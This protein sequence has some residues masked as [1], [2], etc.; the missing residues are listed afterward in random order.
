[1]VAINECPASCST[2]TLGRADDLPSGAV[3]H[4]SFLGVINE[5]II[6]DDM[7]L[8]E[9][10]QWRSSRGLADA[11][12]NAN[13]DANDDDDPPPTVDPDAPQTVLF[14][15]VPPFADRNA[16]LSVSLRTLT[17]PSY[18]T[19]F[20]SGRCRADAEGLLADIFVLK[21]RHFSRDCVQSNLSTAPTTAFGT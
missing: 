8:A 16:F 21:S 10:V 4:A 3:L 19:S 20:F 2:T 1:M 17:G 14:R 6:P 9:V 7:E 15:L 18:G 11:N 12:D 5:M 13:D